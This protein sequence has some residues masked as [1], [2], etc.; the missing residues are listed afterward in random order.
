[1]RPCE[2][3]HPSAHRGSRDERGPVRK[4]L[5]LVEHDWEKEFN[6]H[7]RLPLG[8]YLT[9]VAMGAALGASVTGLVMFL[10]RRCP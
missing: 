3:F 7:D 9:V 6:R 8:W 1:M 4:R 10:V 2:S 5:Q